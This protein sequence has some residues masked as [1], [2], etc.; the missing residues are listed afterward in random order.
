[1]NSVNNFL[2]LSTDNK[3]IDPFK[4]PKNKINLHKSLKL[5]H[6]ARKILGYG[7][8]SARR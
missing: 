8:Q 6:V 2:K 3:S 5:F 4:V 7:S 1:M